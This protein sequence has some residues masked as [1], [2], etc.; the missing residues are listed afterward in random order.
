MS[1]MID[2]GK[3]PVGEIY[4]TPA[5]QETSWLIGQFY[6]GTEVKMLQCR[7]P[8]SSPED[9][10]PMDRICDLEDGHLFNAQQILKIM[11]FI[12]GEHGTNLGIGDLQ[13]EISKWQSF[14][15]SRASLLTTSSPYVITN[16]ELLRSQRGW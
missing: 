7:K 8:L 15:G 14:I 16:A 1:M 12:Q 10:S 4:Q 2:I 3:G 13:S 5:D 11:Q 6:N 9:G